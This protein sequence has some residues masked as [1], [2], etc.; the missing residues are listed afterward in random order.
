VA[1]KTNR[2]RLRP[3]RT[4]QSEQPKCKK[5][6]D[7]FRLLNHNCITLLRVRSFCSNGFEHLSTLWTSFISRTSFVGH[8]APFTFSSPRIQNKRFGCLLCIA[9]KTI[10]NCDHTR[11][12]VQVATRRLEI[13][14]VDHN[15]SQ[16]IVLVQ[17][18]G[19]TIVGCALDCAASIWNHKRLVLARRCSFDSFRTNA[20]TFHHFPGTCFESIESESSAVHRQIELGSPTSADQSSRIPKQIMRMFN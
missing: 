8:R 11:P 14:L 7:R 17:H 10:P 5:S 1:V 3:Q 20:F 4:W 16:P 9:N 13:A 6:N 18:D 12:T 19:A 2:F 15:H